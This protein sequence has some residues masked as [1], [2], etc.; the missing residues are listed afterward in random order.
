MGGG[1]I[2]EEGSGLGGMICE[3]GSEGSGPGGFV[4][5]RVGRMGGGGGID[6]SGLVGAHVWYGMARV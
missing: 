3:A 6:A 2:G 1:G 5:G 4:A